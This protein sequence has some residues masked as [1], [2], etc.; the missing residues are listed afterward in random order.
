MNELDTEWKARLAAAQQRARAS[1]RGDV[2]EYLFLRAENDMARATGVEWL[3]E[4]CTA[5][6][7]E[8]NR[9]GAGLTIARNDSHR[10]SFGNSTMVGTALTF[11]S[12]VRALTVEA[13]WPRAPRD[14]IVRGNG[15][16]NAR[17]SHFGIPKATEDLLLVRNNEGVPQWFV[18]ENSGTRTALLEER[19]RR[20]VAKL[21]N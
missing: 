11:R 8:A 20:H 4:A 12:G 1:G 13:G 16:A 10:F 15:L 5:L 19:I 17:L 9:A 7:G 21:L 3:L 18:L 14:G 6:A 2:A